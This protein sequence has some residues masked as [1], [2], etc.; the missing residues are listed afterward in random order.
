[1]SFPSQ[2]PMSSGMDYDKPEALHP[3]QLYHHAGHQSP[4]PDGETTLHG[5]EEPAVP[6]EKREYRG[7]SLWYVS[8]PK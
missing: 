6:E 3:Q 1:M 4:Q 8:M 7:D 2:S 5:F